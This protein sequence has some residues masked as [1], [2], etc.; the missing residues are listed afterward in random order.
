MKVDRL[1]LRRKRASFVFADD[2]LTGE[3]FSSE[4]RQWL[5][6]WR[7]NELPVACP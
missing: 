1:I 6:M 4:G 2:P 3:V 7:G 5:L